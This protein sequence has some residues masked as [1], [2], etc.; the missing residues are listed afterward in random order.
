[1][2][3]ADI[4]VEDVRRGTNWKFDPPDDEAWTEQP[5]ENWA[6]VVS[7][8]SFAP[9]DHVLYS[10][11]VLLSTGAVLPTLCL[12]EAGSPEYGGDYC[13]FVNAR[14]RQLGL[15]KPDVAIVEEYTA[16]PLAL[17]PSFD[18]DDDLYRAE[19]REG[20]RRFSARIS[21]DVTVQFG[22]Y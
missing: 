8:D 5:M 13:W 20:F 3:I 4:K 15:G 11:L 1:M 21:A 7:S 6:T 9:E 17:D 2:Q 18:S 16:S 19:H 14:W 22:P 12:K 10:G